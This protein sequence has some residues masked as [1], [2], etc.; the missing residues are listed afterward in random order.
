MS[1]HFGVL[2]LHGQPLVFKYRVV[3]LYFFDVPKDGATSHMLIC[4]MHYVNVC[5][6]KCR[7]YRVD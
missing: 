4:I 6:E 7:D 1:Q 3:T 2:V 5:V